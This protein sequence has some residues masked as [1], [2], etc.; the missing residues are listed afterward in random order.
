MISTAKL[1]FFGFLFVTTLVSLTAVAQDCPMG[2]EAHYQPTTFWT[3]PGNGICHLRLWDS[4]TAWIDLEPQ[5]GTYNWTNLDAMLN[6]AQQMGVDVLYTFAKVP[7]WASSNPTDPNCRDVYQAGDCA[8][9]SDVDSGDEYF[10]AFV[11]ALVQHA[12]NRITHYE[13]WNEPYNPPYWD[14]TGAQLATMVFDGAQIIRSLN[15]QA[16][17]LTP[18]ISPWLNHQAF[19]QTFF[20]ASQSLGTTFDVFAMHGYTWGG[21]PEKIVSEV[22]SVLKFRTTVGLDNLPLWGSEGSDKYWSTFTQQY[23]NDFIAR[24]YTLVL[25]YGEK[26]HYW[27]SWN[28]GKVGILMGT[29]GATVY[30]TVSSW[31]SGRTALGCARKAYNGG[32][33]FVCTVQDTVPHRI[34]WVTNGTGT[35]A[36]T[37]T[38]YQTEDGTIN[39]VVGGVVPTSSSPIFITQ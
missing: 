34:V 20:T 36:T 25:N 24:Y 27:Y 28:D 7:K 21:P 11:T 13:M 14:G 15:P 2:M 32:Y 6:V 23:K 39:P 37:A 30:K 18:S 9:P 29:S 1:R 33:Q 10:K 5:N 12:G 26:R 16:V 31:F 38:S 22:Q 35:L 8:P 17:I 19:L 3:L 4:K